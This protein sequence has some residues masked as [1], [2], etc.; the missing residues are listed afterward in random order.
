MCGKG[1]THFIWERVCCR[2]EWGEKKIHDVNLR[3]I[4]ALVENV[5]KGGNFL[6][7]QIRAVFTNYSLELSQS[8]SSEFSIFSSI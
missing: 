7:E 3:F 8:Y 1:L 6:Y 4:H 5:A 2:N